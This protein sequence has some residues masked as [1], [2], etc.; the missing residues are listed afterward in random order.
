MGAG[1]VP[2]PLGNERFLVIYHTGSY[3]KAGGREYTLDAALFNFRRF[4][5][6]YPEAIVERTLQRVMV[7]E[8][9]FERAPEDG[10]DPLHCVFPCGNYEHGEHVHLVYGGRDSYVLAARVK[11]DALLERLASN[12][13]LR[14]A[15]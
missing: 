14:Q 7:P 8:T 15:A 11:K 4:D 6:A 2:I 1:P 10:R 13:E 9:P 5:P 12:R 3:L